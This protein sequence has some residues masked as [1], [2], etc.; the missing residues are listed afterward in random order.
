MVKL[1]KVVICT[2][3]LHFLTSVSRSCQSG[4]IP[5]TP[6]KLVLIRSLLTFASSN[7]I[8]TFHSY[9]PSYQHSIMPTSAVLLKHS[10]LETSTSQPSP[11]CCNSSCFFSAS[12]YR[13][14]L[15]YLAI[16]I[17]NFPDSILGHPFFSF[18]PFSL[19]KSFMLIDS[20]TYQYRSLTQTTLRQQI[21]YSK[22]TDIL[23]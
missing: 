15:P 17:Y 11:S 10:H 22:S 12:L 5:D 4:F 8:D 14:T 18:Y 20:M 2:N 9:L 1:P 6:L 19:E 3:C 23:F 16:K 7:T 21:F 13:S